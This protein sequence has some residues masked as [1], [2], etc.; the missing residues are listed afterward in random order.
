MNR[1]EFKKKYDQFESNFE[2][3]KG[4][5]T[6]QLERGLKKLES[7]TSSHLLKQKLF[8]TRL[9]EAR[10]KEFD[11]LYSKIVN[12]SKLS[13][14]K[15]FEPGHVNDLIGGRIVCHNISDVE[16][17]Y[18]SM[19]SGRWGNVEFIQPDSG[20][21][22]WLKEPNEDGYRG[23][24]AYARWKP[25]G[26][27]K[28]FYA[29]IQIRTILQDAWAT[30]MHDDIYKSDLKGVL[31]S[32]LF[33]H[34]KSYSD[35]FAVLDEQAEHLRQETEEL[36]IKSYSSIFS[37]QLLEHHMN[38]IL[39]FSND[40]L[41][42]M[43]CTKVSRT[44]SFEIDD[45]DGVFEFDVK[46]ECRS[47]MPFKMVIA[48]DTENDNITEF[49]MLA[50]N[51]DGTEEVI[52]LELEKLILDAPNQHSILIECGDD[53]QSSYHLKIRVR[54]NGVFAE[55]FEQAWAP[56][57]DLYGD[58][59]LEYTMILRFPSGVTLAPVAYKLGSDVTSDDVFE[60]YSSAEKPM[61]IALDRSEERGT[62]VFKHTPDESN[63]NYLYLF[64][65]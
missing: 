29:E 20:P 65:Q 15:A 44:D 48:G 62:M 7:T 43:D 61:S 35:L 49:S 41:G 10:V 8:R 9:Q 25:D 56:M 28:A 4:D 30:F 31:P 36:Q 46:C 32:R 19:Y 37:M 57:K 1:A 59:S 58:A 23:A 16:R 14:R 27:K 21:K 26:S 51:S 12:D 53:T 11:S 45:V 52:D 13:L 60:D 42:L 17:I 64:K 55:P 5:L 47:P 33:A 2:E 6:E 39:A 22:N 34:L 50:V 54:W 24:H 38:S 18:K 40:G 63:Q 3:A